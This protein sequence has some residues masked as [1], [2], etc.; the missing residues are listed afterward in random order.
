MASVTFELLPAIPR[1]TLHNTAQM[2]IKK[3]SEKLAIFNFFRSVPVVGYRFACVR[4]GSPVAS[5]PT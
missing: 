4:K 3:I 5:Q 2:Q 1:T